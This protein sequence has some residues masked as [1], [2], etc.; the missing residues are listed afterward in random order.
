M[1]ARWKMGP[2]HR[3]L[4]QR[5][6]D[7]DFPISWV[8]SYGKGPRV[9]HQLGHNAKAFADPALMQHFLAGIQFATR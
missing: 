5:Q 7:L 1:P 6:Q 2:Q 8:K 3:I 9:L 4:K